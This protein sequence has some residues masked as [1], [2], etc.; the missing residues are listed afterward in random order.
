MVLMNYNKTVT[1][2]FVWS[3]A[4]PVKI[5]KLV[6]NYTGPS[7]QF[8]LDSGHKTCPAFSNYIPCCDGCSISTAFVI[9]PQLFFIL[10]CH[11][12]TRGRAGCET[13]TSRKT[14]LTFIKCNGKPTGNAPR[15]RWGREWP[16]QASERWYRSNAPLRE[17]RWPTSHWWIQS[18]WEPGPHDFTSASVRWWGLGSWGWRSWKCQPAERRWASPSATKTI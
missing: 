12:V 5:W 6:N 9:P 2:W 17:H 16:P 3:V 4:F 13:P 14:C 10:I 8:Q 1:G 11:A 7:F 18:V 15:R